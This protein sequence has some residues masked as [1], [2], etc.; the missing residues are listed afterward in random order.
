MVVGKEV[1]GGCISEEGSG[2]PGVSCA[3]VCEC[4]TTNEFNE[5]PVAILAQAISA[6]G[7]PLVL[8]PLHHAW[9]S[10]GYN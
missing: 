2:D 7:P 4:G 5:F 9:F 6:G 10:P 3:P 8:H 1:Q